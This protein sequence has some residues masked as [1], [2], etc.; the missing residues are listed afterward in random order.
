MADCASDCHSWY[1]QVLCSPV[2][3]SSVRDSVRLYG[4]RG[5]QKFKVDETGQRWQTNGIF[6]DFV[7]E[8]SKMLWE[9]S[10]VER[11]MEGE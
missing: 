10:P 1:A 6:T 8:D 3:L 7:G 11:V 4:A 2:T 9:L 5:V